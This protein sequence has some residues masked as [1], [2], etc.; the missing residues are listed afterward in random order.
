MN[1]FQIGAF[2]VPGGY[3]GWIRKV[4][5]A[6][7]EI[8]KSDRGHPIVFTSKAEA[9][10]AA[11]EAM[12]EYLNSPMLRSGDRI[13]NAKSVAEAQFNLPKLRKTA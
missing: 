1:S 5:R 6:D 2:P 3:L 11:G 12:C 10:A 7:N 13:E 4:H 9:K 8:L